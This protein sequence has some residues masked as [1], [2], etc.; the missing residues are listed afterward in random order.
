MA[1][2]WFRP[3]KAPGPDW[4]LPVYEAAVVDQLAGKDTTRH[5]ADPDQI[6]EIAVSHDMVVPE[7]APHKP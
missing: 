1:Q 7:E 6:I 5:A 4:K 2:P 3:T